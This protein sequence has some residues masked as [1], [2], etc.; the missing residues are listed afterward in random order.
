MFKCVG[1]IVF[2]KDVEKKRRRESNNNK[3]SHSRPS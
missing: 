1:G 2:E 3:T